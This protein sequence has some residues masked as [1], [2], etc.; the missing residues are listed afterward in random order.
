M[1]KPLLVKLAAGVAAAAVFAF[2]FARSLED[3]RTA[4]YT[5]PPEHLR[6]WTLAL[7]AAPDPDDPL[8]VLRPSPEL[9]TSLFKQVFARAMESL[10]TPERPSVPVMMRR[11]FDQVVG[12]QMTQD[13]LL[14]AAR[15]AGV[16]SAPTPRCLVHRRVS[17]PGDVRQVYF[18]YLDAPAIARFRKQVGLDPDALSPILFVAG[19]GPDFNSWLPQRVN[20]DSDCLAPVDIAS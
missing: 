14:S 3:T 2:L 6:S 18:I 7:E 20:P 13:A 19:A 8:L 15:A 12:D 9:A 1:K 11:E 5:I 4:P 10:N 17:V 16:E